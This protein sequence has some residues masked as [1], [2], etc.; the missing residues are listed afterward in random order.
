MDNTETKIINAGNAKYL[1][2]IPGFTDLPAN[3][4]F[5]K[6]LTGSGGTTVALENDVPYV[7]CMPYVSLIKNKMEWCTEHNVT[8]LPVFGE[9]VSS[10]DVAEFDGSKIMVTYDSL[11]KVV[12]GLGSRV[13]DF[14]I[15][16]DEYH[17]LINSGAFRYKAVNEVLRLYQEFGEHVFMTATP[18]RTEFLP[19][20][21]Q[22]IPEVSV[23]WDNLELV[24]LD[25][26]VLEHD[27]LYPVVANIAY[28]Y[29]TGK[30]DGNAYFFL[31]S[32]QGIIDII[33]HLKKV[34]V[35]HEDIRIVCA[36]NQDN[37][38][39]LRETIGAKYVIGQLSDFPKKLN[40]ITSTAFEGSDLKDED[41][42]TYIVSDGRKAH[43]KYDIMTTI[44]QIIGRNRVAKKRNWAKIIYSPS[45]YCEM[46]ESVFVEYVK[47][48]LEEAHETVKSYRSL[49]DPVA[50]KYML[51]GVKQEDSTYLVVNGNRIEVN[52]TA[53]CA[54][55][56]QF[57]A[58]HHT[59][60]VKR[61]DEGKPVQDKSSREK[62]INGVPYKLNSIPPD[63][64]RL[65][66]LESVRL[67]IQRKSFKELVDLYNG[68]NKPYQIIAESDEQDKKMIEKL[69]PLIPEAI[70]TIGYD[71][72]VSLEYHQKRV[73]A[74]VLK[75]ETLNNP[76]KVRRLLDPYNYRKGKR[77]PLFQIKEDLQ[78]AFT[79]LGID[80]KAKANHLKSVFGVKPCKVSVNG[81][82]V[83]GYK[84]LGKL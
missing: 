1:G 12:E 19:E 29:T 25:Y 78:E 62:S 21:L 17:L 74:E 71:K 24:T 20:V 18:V 55:M 77:I 42:I 34:N 76:A 57:S 43:T 28:E 80:V 11:H 49:V 32:V 61:D 64:I 48:K 70:N 6:V 45:P 83:N 75:T 58:I 73:Q 10:A 23:K 50:R 36:D 26:S 72:I 40:F 15:L 44:P 65:N 47:K 3:C 63:D 16:V 51:E 38:R 69:Y 41:G 60:Y 27:Q 7:L 84:I 8:A 4:R 37:K 52:E 33:Y 2:E 56:Q 22:G 5:N 53:K 82:R 9:Q 46:E 59:Y 30:H 13:E 81:A 67:G 35:T 54:E 39:R 31:N 79:M 66:R 68:W 14:K